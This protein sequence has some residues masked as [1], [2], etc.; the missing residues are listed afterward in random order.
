MTALVAV[1]PAVDGGRGVLDEQDVHQLVRAWCRARD[2]GAGAAELSRYLAL[3]GLVVH[4]PQVTLRGVEEFQAWY[5][6]TR[7]RFGRES[8]RV[9]RVDVRLTSPLHAEATVRLRWQLRRPQSP[10]VWIGVDAVQHWSV[11]RQA[12]AVRVRTCA[13]DQA[14][15]LPGSA[16]LDLIR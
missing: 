14:L 16:S 8:H 4:L 13:M 12:G 11:V 3:D 1:P 5:V 10:E 2:R 6:R 7:T 15:V 9:E